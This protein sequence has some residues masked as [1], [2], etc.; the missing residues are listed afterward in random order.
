M[1]MLKMTLYMVMNHERVTCPNQV[2]HH[3]CVSAAVSSPASAVVVSA[4]RAPGW[5]CFA[6]NLTLAAHCTTAERRCCH[7][8]CHLTPSSPSLSSSVLS[9]LALTTCDGSCLLAMMPCVL[10]GFVCSTWIQMA[11]VIIQ[12]MYNRSVCMK[13]HAHNT[14]NSDLVTNVH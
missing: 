9:S 1:M 6:W 10:P 4:S 2:H 12:N 7:F 13:N 14:L 11:A 5:R 8:P 3:C